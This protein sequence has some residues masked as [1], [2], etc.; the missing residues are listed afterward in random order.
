MRH[1][2]AGMSSY[3][4]EYTHTSMHVY[5]EATVPHKESR[6]TIARQWELLQRIPKGGIGKSY[7]KLLEELNEMFKVS[8]R[9]VDRDLKALQTIFPDKL[10]CNADGNT[11]YWRW[12]INAHINIPGM[13]LTDALSLT[14][15][16]DALHGLLPKVLLNAMEPQFAA[17]QEKL[18]GLNSPKNN[19]PLARWPTL[20]RS[21]IPAMP[22]LAPQISDEVLLNVQTAL[23]EN[24]QIEVAYWAMDTN[25]PKT[26]SL[27]P[28]ALVNR[29]VVTYLVATAWRYTDVR[30]YALHRI[31]SAQVKISTALRPA[32]FD[33]DSYIASGA[34]QFGD[35]NE[36]VLTARVTDNLGRILRETRLSDD[37]TIAD[38][39]L[40]ATVKDTRQL[41]WWLLSQESEIEVTGPQ[42][43][44]D[45]IKASL[46]ETLAQYARGTEKNDENSL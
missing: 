42:A 29:G 41:R 40:R 15:I 37:Q 9:Q 3:F 43:L 4:V 20:A 17:A 19:T 6:E 31:Q 35:G 28:L 36:L 27:N 5:Q 10:E 23:L 16:S 14:M 39:V 13:Q 11:H 45:W 22:M 12:K 33:L 25:A 38:G 26:M 1:I 2:L 24:V 30:H 44:V 7:S 21:V 46:S 32:D 34:M 18:N 8:K